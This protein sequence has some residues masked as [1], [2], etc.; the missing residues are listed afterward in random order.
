MKRLIYFSLLCFCF[1]AFT[2]PILGAVPN[3]TPTNPIPNNPTPEVPQIDYWKTI[4]GP[5][6][7]DG[8]LAIYNTEDSDLAITWLNK[9]TI[10]TNKLTRETWSV[11]L[12]FPLPILNN[13]EG[14]YT[15]YSYKIDKAGKPIVVDA[16]IENFSGYSVYVERWNGNT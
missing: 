10:L 13:S 2:D 4:G 5:F 12:S 8:R 16:K 3:P 14:V 11:P 7:S 1:T 6:E 15:T 9:N